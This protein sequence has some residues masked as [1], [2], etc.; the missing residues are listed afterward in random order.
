MVMQHIYALS[1]AIIYAA[2]N[3]LTCG[4]IHERHQGMNLQ[5][6]KDATGL[7]DAAIGERLGWS[8]S[9]IHRVRMG[10]CRTTPRMVK[11]MER[12][13]ADICTTEAAQ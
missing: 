2:H 4:L 10:V 11:A 1:T 8:Q 9:L 13:F 3:L 5:Q 12:E 6:I 7:S